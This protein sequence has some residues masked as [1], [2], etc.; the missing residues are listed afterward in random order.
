MA[1]CGSPGNVYRIGGL[2]TIYSW[3]VMN[4]L[5]QAD[6]EQ[7]ASRIP[8]CLLV[9]K[10]EMRLHLST[11]NMIQSMQDITAFVHQRI[12]TDACAHKRDGTAKQVKNILF[13]S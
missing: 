7:V 2:G 6:G 5:L 11:G 3:D 13:Y 1:K 9:V 8:C 10:N 12:I 4:A